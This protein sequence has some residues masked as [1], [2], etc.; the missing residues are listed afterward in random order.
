MSAELTCL[1]IKNGLISCDTVCAAPSSCSQLSFCLFL[2]PS[3]WLYATSFLSQSSRKKPATINLFRSLSAVVERS[4]INRLASSAL[5]GE[6]GRGFISPTPGEVPSSLSFYPNT[7]QRTPLSS[8]DLWQDE[9]IHIT[10][11]SVLPARGCRKSCATFPLSGSLHRLHHHNPNGDR[12]SSSDDSF[13][14]ISVSEDWS[15]AQNIPSDCHFS[16]LARI[17]I[18]E[19]VQHC[20]HAKTDPSVGLPDN[21][22][23]EENKSGE[24]ARCSHNKRV[25]GMVCKSHIKLFIITLL[26]ENV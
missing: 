25:Q 16:T 13:H 1:H 4:S 23:I 24:E 17:W 12:Y 6:G 14:S 22:R 11:P 8:R 15:F 9:F 3:V 20:L 19:S 7:H 2:L 18:E 21:T 5:C 26:M 10:E